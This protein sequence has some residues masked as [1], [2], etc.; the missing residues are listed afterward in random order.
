MLVVEDSFGG[1][2]TPGGVIPNEE[3]DLT[4]KA[5]VTLTEIV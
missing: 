5:N 4:V 1:A 2:I 3:R